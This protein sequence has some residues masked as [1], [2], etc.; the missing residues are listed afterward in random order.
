MSQ[1]PQ[2]EKHWKLSRFEEG[3]NVYDD[4][5]GDEGGGDYGSLG[6]IE[7]LSRA[8][9]DALAKHQTRQENHARETKGII[10]ERQYQVRNGQRIASADMQQFGQDGKA[11]HPVLGD[12][13]QFSGMEDNDPLADND[14]N[15]ERQHELKMRHDHNP[16]PAPRTMPTP[17][18]TR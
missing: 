8:E 9:R 17:T 13:A 2:E 3:L 5:G 18:L 11:V 7:E 4:D 15:S 6:G 14:N 10:L 12:K 16:A 1:S